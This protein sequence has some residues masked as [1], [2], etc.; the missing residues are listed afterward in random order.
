MQCELRR[1]VSDQFLQVAQR[2]ASKQPTRCLPLGLPT[3]RLPSTC[4]TFAEPRE[5]AALRR[6]VVT[7]ILH[8]WFYTANSRFRV[9]FCTLFCEL[10]GLLFR[11]VLKR[12]LVRD[13]HVRNIVPHFLR[14]FKSVVRTVNRS[15]ACKSFLNVQVFPERDPP[16]PVERREAIHAAGHDVEP[17]IASMSP[18]PRR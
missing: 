16:H 13:S 7:T 12:C 5:A 10:A 11:S 1:V 14:H 3:L 9:T 2:A 17:A 8:I 4:N 6:A 15:S 18:T